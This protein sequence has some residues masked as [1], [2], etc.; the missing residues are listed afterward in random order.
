MQT[1]IATL[2]SLRLLLRVGNADVL[3]GGARYRVAVGWEVI[4]NIG[5][6]VGVEVEEWIGD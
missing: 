6:S 4:R 1:A 2:C 5:R 3:D